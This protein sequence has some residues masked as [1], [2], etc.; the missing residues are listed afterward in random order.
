MGWIPW[1]LPRGPP[2]PDLTLLLHGSYPRTWPSLDCTNGLSYF[3][4]LPGLF[5]HLRVAAP[6]LSACL[7]GL[8]GESQRAGALGCR[9]AG[10]AGCGGRGT[11]AWLHSLDTCHGRPGPAGQ[12]GSSSKCSGT[13]Q[14]HPWKDTRTAVSSGALQGAHGVGGQGGYGWVSLSRDTFLLGEVQ[15]WDSGVWGLGT[16]IPAV[17]QLFPGL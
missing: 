2:S 10:W 6:S 7:L 11:G 16:G 4:T 12:L 1:S 15:V 8:P 5:L 3:L 17:P 9:Q 13:P 14:S